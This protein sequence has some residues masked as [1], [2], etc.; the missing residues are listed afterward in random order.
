MQKRYTIQILFIILDVNTYTAMHACT[1]KRVKNLQNFNIHILH[2][3]VYNVLLWVCC[4]CY[5]RLLLVSIPP[6]KAV[7]LTFDHTKVSLQDNS[8]TLFEKWY[9]GEWHSPL[10]RSQ[11]KEK[12]GLTS[13]VL[14]MTGGRPARAHTC[15]CVVCIHKKL[16]HFVTNTLLLHRVQVIM[17]TI[18]LHLPFTSVH[19][20]ILNILDKTHIY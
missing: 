7:L 13:S 14:R 9:G 18:V 5:N 15:V 10:Q 20:L 11:C 16:Y 1:H 17:P 2:S 8:M 4:Y 19:E 3:T 6:L 12:R